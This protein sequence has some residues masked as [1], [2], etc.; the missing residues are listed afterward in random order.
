M[1]MHT[2]SLTQ[3]KAQI[4]TTL[5]YFDFIIGHLLPFNDNFSLDLNN[6]SEEKLRMT[7]WIRKVSQATSDLKSDFFSLVA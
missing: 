5:F 2:E 6:F 7:H 3:R 4:A 1:I